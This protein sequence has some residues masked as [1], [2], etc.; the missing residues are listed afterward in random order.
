VIE[1]SE[2]RVVACC[3]PFII[4]LFNGLLIALIH[5]MFNVT[6]GTLGAMLHAKSTHVRVKRSEMYED[7]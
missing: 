1:T 5:N 4:I 6:S 3:L 2:M 7:I